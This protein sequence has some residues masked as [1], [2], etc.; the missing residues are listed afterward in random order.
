MSHAALRARRGDS[1][2]PL[3]PD[4]LVSCASGLDAAQRYL[5]RVRLAVAAKV[6]RAGALDA[7]RLEREQFAAHGYA[8]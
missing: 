1:T 2:A 5:G 8:W 7:D 4:L 6:T 3:L